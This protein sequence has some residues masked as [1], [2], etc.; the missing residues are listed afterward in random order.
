[1]VPDPARCAFIPLA[2]AKMRGWKVQG[3]KSAV[4][5]ARVVLDEQRAPVMVLD[6]GRMYPI[7]AAVVRDVNVCLVRCLHP[8]QTKG[9]SFV[10][11]PSEVKP[12]QQ[13]CTGTRPVGSVRKRHRIRRNNSSRVLETQVGVLQSVHNIRGHR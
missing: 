13:F 11:Q 7:D 4:T 1:M 9:A 3:A 2:K 8:K 12:R 5:R 6:G 10:S